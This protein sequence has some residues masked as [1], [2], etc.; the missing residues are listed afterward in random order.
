[1]ATVYLHL[2]EMQTELIKS[3]NRRLEDEPATE[4]AADNTTR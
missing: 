3:L 2:A 4:L 1:M